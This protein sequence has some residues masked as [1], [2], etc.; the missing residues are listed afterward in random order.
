VSK[1]PRRPRHERREHERALRKLVRDRETLASLEPGGSAERPI[2]VPTSSV[3]EV[4]ARATPGPQCAGE[5]GLDDHAVATHD[6]ELLRALAMT[7]RRCHA[8]RT[9]WFRIVPPLAN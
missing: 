4:R 1:K 3:I 8:R 9:L 5:L 2:D 6:G 7:C